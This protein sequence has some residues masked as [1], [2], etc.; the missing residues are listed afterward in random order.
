V[1]KKKSPEADLEKCRQALASL[2]YLSEGSV[3]RRRAGTAGS[4]YLWTRKVKAKTVSV[5]LSK[6]QYQ[7]L[8]RATR[9][10]RQALRLLDKMSRLSR[11]LLFQT[12]PGVPRRK[13][14]SR[15]VLGL[16]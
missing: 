8:R 12:I 16:V 4:P 6:E 3:I 14:L 7:W 1:N 11:E 10:H 9:N 5:S 2:G 15:K 13:K